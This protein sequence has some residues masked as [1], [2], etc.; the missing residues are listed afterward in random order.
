M[1]TPTSAVATKLRLASA[2]QPVEKTELNPLEYPCGVLAVIPALH[3][4]QYYQGL[5]A[6]AHNF[7]S[8]S[9]CDIFEIREGQGKWQRSLDDVGI[10]GYLL[11]CSKTLPTLQAIFVTLKKHPATSFGL[12]LSMSRHALNSVLSQ[13]KM[14]P[15]FVAHLLGEP[16][17]WAPG[18]FA[19]CGKSQDLKQIEFFCQHPRWNIHQ[20]QIPW[21]IYMAYD[22]PQGC[23]TYFVVSEENYASN[24]T[25]KERLSETFKPEMSESLSANDPFMLH[26]MV[27]H[28][29]LIQSKSVTTDLRY[30]LYDQLDKVDEY[31]A[32]PSAHRRN[33]ETLTTSLHIIS[34]NA[35]SLIASADMAATIA[36]LMSSAHDRFVTA[37]RGDPNALSSNKSI[38]ISDSIRYLL[39]SIRAEKRWLLSYK[40]RKDI[41]MNLVVF[42]LVTQQ[43]SQTNLAIALD[44]KRDSKSMNVIAALTMCG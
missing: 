4:I 10:E 21:S 1:A 31:A 35:D 34:Q 37:H 36:D 39:N 9:Q 33:L 32:A 19:H 17:Y 41:A 23:A 5:L 44:T 27:A 38:E 14:S 13:F 7:S 26:V 24:E 20:K 30:K 15:Q 11:R 40:N 2:Y 12:Q 16:D 18:D 42:N 43:D 22:I 8:N 29:S 6:N 25:V 3:D 28:E